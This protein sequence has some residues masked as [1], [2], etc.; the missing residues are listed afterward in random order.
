[1]E[2]SK[3]SSKSD[4]A[5]ERYSPEF[6]ASEIRLG[7]KRHDTFFQDAKESIDVYNARHKWA[8][9][10]LERRISCWWY[11][12]NTILPAY[13]SSTPKVRSELRKKAGTQAHQMTSLILE[14]GTQYAMD[15]FFDFDDVALGSALEF[16]LTGRGIIW[17]RYEADIDEG[18]KEFALLKDG[19]GG[20]L[21]AQGNPYE[22]DHSKLTTTEAGATGMQPYKE[23]KGERAVLELVNHRDYLTGDGRNRAEVEWRAR[24]AYM[25][26]ERV[27]SLGLSFGNDLK[28]N[29]YPELLEE[30]SSEKDKTKYEGKAELWEIHCI[31]TGK[32]YWA[33]IDGK[34]SDSCD[35]SLSF[36][37]FYPCVEIAASTD[38]TSVIPVSDYV[39]VRDI[40]IET[41]RLTTRIHYAIEAVRA[42]FAYDAV[43]EDTIQG[44]ISGDLKGIPVKN[45]PSQVRRGGLAGAIE[46]HNVDPYIKALQILVDART[47]AF[48]RLCDAMKAS[49]LMRGISDPTKTATAN[50][51]ESSWSSLGLIVRQNQFAKFIGDAIGKLAS[52]IAQTFDPERI[53]EMADAAEL[54]QQSPNVP[55]EEVIQIIRNDTERMYRI[56]V[57]SDSM[58]ALDERQDRQDRADLMSSAG[59]FFEQLEGIIKEYPPVAPF[60]IG[61]MQ[62]V[63]RS[64]K[65]GKELEPLFLQ[66]TN[67]VSQMAQ[68]KTE[69]QAQMPPSPG[70][71]EAQTRVQIAQMQSQDAHQKTLLE[72]QRMQQDAAMDKMKFQLD[73]ETKIKELEIRA[74][75]VRISLLQVQEKA[76]ADAVTAGIQKDLNETKAVIEQQRVEIEKQHVQLT[77]FEK[78]LQEKRLNQVELGIGA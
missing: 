45:W 62:Y 58:V 21:D 19:R 10:K 78:L 43:M 4:L 50:R 1:M 36:E 25:S 28:F 29:S 55:R 54:F 72:L 34:A 32:M 23:K 60:G 9:L 33:D 38:P 49:D 17:C 30:R 39:H 3:T 64:Y 57:S 63:C 2:E 69:Q 5:V 22:G 11:V 35:P 59:A 27:E 73:Y 75:E 18:E 76:A 26:R 67:V 8:D 65:G 48:N 77:A 40:V 42:N 71:I 61:L 31:A 6:W 51:L 47:E 16:L 20:L 56:Q 37:D 24:R 13:Y 74:D 7:L 52:T 53:F 46:Y 44:L 15:E 12:T 41:E 14:R 70:V 66:M 68:Q